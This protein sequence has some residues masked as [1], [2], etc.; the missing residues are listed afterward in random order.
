MVKYSKLV[1]IDCPYCDH[2]L[3]RIV[4]SD[5][6]IHWHCDGCERTAYIYL[7][8]EKEWQHWIEEGNDYDEEEGYWDSLEDEEVKEL[9]L[10]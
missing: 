1:I 7:N 6:E 3:R 8:K 4:Y 9:G 10:M 5:C 2:E